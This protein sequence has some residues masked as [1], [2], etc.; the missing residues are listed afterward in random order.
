MANHMIG[1][2]LLSIILHPFSTP[3]YLE[4]TRLQNQMSSTTVRIPIQC[5]WKKSPPN[6]HALSLIRQVRYEVEFNENENDGM[7]DIFEVNVLKP[8]HEQ[9]SHWQRFSASYLPFIKCIIYRTDLYI[10]SLD[11]IV[12]NR[13]KSSYSMEAI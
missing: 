12:E 3:Q 1:S 7:L 11:S 8:I 4:T 5:H 2:L 10:D 9:R 6:A 13:P